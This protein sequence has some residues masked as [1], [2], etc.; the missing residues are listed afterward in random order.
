VLYV[1]MFLGGGENWLSFLAKLF[2]V[3]AIPASLACV[4]PRYRAEDVLRLL[5]KWPVLLGLAGIWLV[6]R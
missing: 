3:M 4:F 2:A 1:T 6:M 5:W